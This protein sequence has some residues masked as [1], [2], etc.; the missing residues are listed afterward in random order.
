MNLRLCIQSGPRIK[1]NLCY[2]NLKSLRVKTGLKSVHSVWTVQK[3]KP[4]SSQSTRGP[5]YFLSLM[6]M[7]VIQA[8]NQNSRSSK[9][10][11]CLKKHVNNF[12]ESNS[13][14]TLKKSLYNI[15]LSTVNFVEW[16]V[17]DS[18]GA[19][20]LIT[21]FDYTTSELCSCPCGLGGVKR[22]IFYFLFLSILEI[23]RIR[24]V[25]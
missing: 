19:T 21:S 24:Y 23:G 6:V 4:R 5:W 2:F 18:N 10:A 14:A 1:Q 20:K 3:M 25:I 22:T 16:G 7:P 17:Y 11:A 12:N 15:L 9:L 8:R 13:T